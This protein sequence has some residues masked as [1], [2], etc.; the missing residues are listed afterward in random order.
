MAIKRN[1]KFFYLKDKD[2]L[3]EVLKECG[4][5][6]KS[7]YRT[8]MK[9]IQLL[10]K[11]KDDAERIIDKG[12]SQLQQYGVTD[13][14]IRSSLREQMSKV[15]TDFGKVI[16]DAKIT[17]QAKDDQTSLFNIVLFGKTMCGKSTLM[18]ILTHGDGTSIGKGGQRTTR[19]VRKY[20]WNG[21]TITDVPGVE[22][23]GGEDDEK[24]A[25]EEARVADLIIFMITDGQPEGDEADWLIKLKR[26]DKPMICVCNKKSA[27][28]TDLQKKR[29]LKN[30]EKYMNADSIQQVIEQF[31]EFVATELP[32]ER[33]NFCVVHLLAK[34]ES[35]HNDD[36][37]VCRILNR[38]SKFSFL[39]NIICK[40]VA[41]N[42]VLY[43]KRSY[44]SIIDVPVYSL[45]NS[46]LD[47]SYQSLKQANNINDKIKEFKSWIERFREDELTTLRNFIDTQYRRIED[48]IPNFVEENVENRNAQLVWNR[49]VKSYKIEDGIKNKL[50]NSLRHAQNK[51]NELFNDIDEE[52]GF[53]LNEDA[54]SLSDVT[55][56]NWRK[57]FGWGS[58]ISGAISAVVFFF[59]L[60]NPIGWIFAGLAAAFQLFSWFS[61]SREKKKR[62]AMQRI[63]NELNKGIR[64]SHQKIENQVE[65]IF[66]RKMDE[67]Q[68]N[69]LNALYTLYKSFLTM[70]NTH[71]SLAWNNCN[72]HKL[73]SKDIIKFVLEELGMPNDE[74]DKIMDVARIPGKHCAIVLKDVIKKSCI[75]SICKNTDSKGIIQAIGSKLGSKE[76]IDII[77]KPSVNATFQRLLI[78]NHIRLGK[79]WLKEEEGKLL[80]YVQK[81]NFSDEEKDKLNI[82]QQLLNVHIIG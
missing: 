24:L 56:T 8:S 46:M 81:K 71:R 9:Y 67:L 62:D 23:F 80:C 2:E 64:K 45:Y 42:G 76:Y 40:E 51:I 60:S 11:A 59:E 13:D 58:A 32:N 65:K 55:F 4:R 5:A 48:D 38:A 68:R 36:P 50:D 72:N 19:D 82:I 53:L 66:N 44:L 12:L 29:F 31:N 6:K 14:S 43:R 37:E 49:R 78:R 73:I 79:Y 18:E 20:E 3:K 21:M 57:W 63:T 77:T 61:D 52:A 75:D 33:L 17:I 7:S 1:I 70:T 15:Q 39:E 22:A 16:T 74:R 27:L 25:M 10:S 69:T 41:A 47:F 54:L 30:P 26:M 28:S 34:Y 35:M